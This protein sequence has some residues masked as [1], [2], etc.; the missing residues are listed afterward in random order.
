MY[1]AGVLGTAC[2]IENRVNKK[3]NL[4]DDTELD[5]VDTFCYLG[6]SLNSEGRSDASIVTHVRTA[7]VL[8]NIKGIII[9]NLW[10]HLHDLYSTSPL[11]LE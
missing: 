5:I 10:E 6:D 2:P 4:T 1:S 9:V 7:I 11:I 3:W 8:A